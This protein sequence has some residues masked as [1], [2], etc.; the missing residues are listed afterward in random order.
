MSVINIGPPQEYTLDDVRA[1]RQFRVPKLPEI[2]GN[3]R[4]KIDE[5][6]ETLNANGNTI[7]Y[8][9]VYAGHDTDLPFKSCV[10]GHR[11]YGPAVLNGW[12]VRNGVDKL[13]DSVMDYYGIEYETFGKS[14]EDY[15]DEN[16][17][18]DDSQVDDAVSAFLQKLY[19]NHVQAYLTSR[20][21]R[22][23]KQA[24]GS[25][26]VRATNWMDGELYS[27]NK[28]SGLCNGMKFDIAPAYG[29]HFDFGVR[30]PKTY[31]FIT[32]NLKMKDDP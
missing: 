25:Y 13:H 4:V 16:D 6:T 8:G 1:C 27:H 2:Q 28:C 7:T 11:A 17:E 26:D 29:R 22:L 14:L 24:S 9:R 5:A 3:E 30:F 19:D 18:S 15:I 21:I 10:A 31:E 20:H 12:V 32:E 23:K